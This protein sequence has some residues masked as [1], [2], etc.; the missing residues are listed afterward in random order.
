MIF[1]KVGELAPAA[2]IACAWSA[3]RWSAHW[4]HVFDRMA[5]RIGKQRAIT[6][7]ARKLL[8][9]IWYVLTK[10]Q[11]DRFADPEAVARSLM[12]WSEL[13]HLARS[14]GVPR[15]EFVRSRL[16]RLDMCRQ[17]ASFRANGRT[18]YLAEPA[19]VAA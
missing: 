6:A 8:V 3:V 11:A 2:L 13:H 10:R 15:I 9:V 1:R 17:V 16:D 5:K 14:Q 18:H 19:C 4:Q 12:R 7:V